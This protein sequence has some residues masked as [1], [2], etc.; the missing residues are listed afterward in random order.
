MFLHNKLDNVVSSDPK[1]RDNTNNLIWKKGLNTVQLA[2][3]RY[4]TMLFLKD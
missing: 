2:I 4:Q 3:T 1:E